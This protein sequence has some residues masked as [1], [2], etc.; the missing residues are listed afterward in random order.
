MNNLALPLCPKCGETK[1]VFEY[2]GHVKLAQPYC[3]INCEIYWSTDLK[4]INLP[5]GY[6]EW[7]KQK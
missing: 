2:N 3:C 1:T 5:K 4:I 6:E 7:I